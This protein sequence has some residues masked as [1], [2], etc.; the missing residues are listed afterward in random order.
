MRP[1]AGPG[2]MAPT[3]RRLV[4]RT[5]RSPT[6]KARPNAP[7]RTCAWS[8]PSSNRRFAIAAKCSARR[9]NSTPPT[10]RPPTPGSTAR[11]R[12]TSLP[13]P[14]RDSRI[15][16]RTRRRN[17]RWCCAHDFGSRSYAPRKSS[18]LWMR[19]LTK[20][21]GADVSSRR[22][23]C[24]RSIRP[25]RRVPM[26]GD[27]LSPRV[28][29]RPRSRVS[30]PTSRARTGVTRASRCSSRSIAAIRRISIARAGRS[31]PRCIRTST[32]FPKRSARAWPRQHSARRTP[33]R[34]I[35]PNS[36]DWLSAR[37][38]GR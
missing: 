11:S 14:R 21:R 4:L 22:C 3:P 15:F 13:T 35:S 38:E 33:P 18:P 26:N 6:S 25:R 37:A 2:R 23:M 16:R 36:P 19:P 34:P 9:S 17:P 10:G 5:R 30:S 32:R 8:G 28:S 27:R 12:Q 1:R 29:T 20:A 31:C 24:G 7:W